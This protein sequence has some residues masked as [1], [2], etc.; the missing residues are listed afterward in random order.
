MPRAGHNAFIAQVSNAGKIL[1]AKQLAGVGNITGQASPSTPSGTIAAAGIYDGHHHPGQ[2]I[3][4][5]PSPANTNMFLTT[6]TSRT[7]G[8]YFG[9]GKTDLAIYNQLHRV[10]LRRSSRASHGLVQHSATAG[11][12][13]RPDRRATSTATARPTSP[14]TTAPPPPSA[15]C[16]PAAAASMQQFGTAGHDNIPVAGRLRRR[17][18]DRPGHLRPDRRLHQ[19]PVLRRA[20][21]SSSSSASPATTASRSRATST[22]TARPTS[23][24]TTAPTASSQSCTPPAAAASIQQFGI[25]GHDSVPI[26]G[27]FDG[28]GKT[29]L[30]IYDR[31]SSIL[32]ALYSGGGGIFQ[33]FGDHGHDNVPLAGDYDGDGKT[34]ISHLRPHQRH[35][36][37][38]VLRR[39]RDRPAVRRRLAGD[40]EPAEPDLVRPDARPRLG[41]RRPPGDR[42]RPRP[43][44]GHA[45][46]ARPGDPREEEGRLTRRPPSNPR[47]PPSG[48]PFRR[49]RSVCGPRKAPTQDPPSPHLPAN[50]AQFRAPTT[51]PAAPPGPPVV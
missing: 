14:S 25:P 48:P 33:Q 49:A 6:L 7:P 36:Q 27:D 41:G 30:A 9:D 8:D 38:P 2:L 18:Q 29:D 47:R 42:H 34:D 24:S 22:A 28:D 26:A 37:H 17:R 4:P 43:D 15:S 11:A 12:R 45:G 50:P 40:Q 31:T 32:S 46:R 16:T 44:L 13:Q 1:Q 10:P 39:R 5:A 23:P 19:R 3:P 35:V 51:P 21:A 20:A